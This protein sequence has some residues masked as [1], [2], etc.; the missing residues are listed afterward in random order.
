M[1]KL[2]VRHKHLH[3]PIFQKSSLI[4]IDIEFYKEF[5]IHLKTHSMMANIYTNLTYFIMRY[6][7]IS[8]KWSLP[9][10]AS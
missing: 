8:L 7:T 10:E 9:S 2:K 6:R 5:P 3:N 4:N 1:K